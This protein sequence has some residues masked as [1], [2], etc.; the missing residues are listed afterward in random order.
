MTENPHSTQAPRKSRA[1]KIWG[2]VVLVVGSLLSLGVLSSAASGQMAQARAEMAGDTTAQIN[3]T[4][5][6]LAVL[7]LVP[8]GIW[9]IVRKPKR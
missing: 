1:S 5:M 8:L 2:I 9:L 3:Y 7:L 4:A 6:N